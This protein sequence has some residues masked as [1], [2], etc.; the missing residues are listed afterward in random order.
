M[1]KMFYS[2]EEAA[3]KLQKSP[4]E[5]RAMAERDELKEYRDG[6][7]L[8]YKVDQVDL[9]SDDHD[10]GDIG[11]SD[12]SGMISLQDTGG[13]QGLGLEET[14]G[15]MVGL[16][17]SSAQAAS[18]KGGD[19]GGGEAAETVS[20]GDS[21][22]GI[23]VLDD[24]DL[25]GAD[26]SA[27]TLVTDEPGLDNV[28]LESFGSGSGLMDLTRESDDTSLGM[29]N[30]GL[31]DE[32]YSGGDAGSAETATAAG[33]DLFEGSAAGDEF[34]P[35]AAPAGAVAAAPEV[36]DGKGSGLAGGLALGMVIA[37][38]LALAVVA[39][40][41][42]G[43]LPELASTLNIAEQ[44]LLI[45]IAALLVLTLILGAVGFLFGGKR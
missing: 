12:L 19:A 22:G 3:D 25:G 7:R 26:A 40:S 37:L 32:L 15:S 41:L 18:D 21:G 14:G 20:S 27:D 31:L 16:A 5:V 11:E 1:A 45:P 43:G 6:D 30:E 38:G 44:G 13:T 2:L 4:D 35:G 42:M 24:D 36:Y 9:L 23:T 17:D 8:I 28:N 33:D 39:M 34:A 29:G 10:A